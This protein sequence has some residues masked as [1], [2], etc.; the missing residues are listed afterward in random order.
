MNGLAKSIQN[1][2]TT[3]KLALAGVVIIII[4]FP[5]VLVSA[6][7]A[8]VGNGSKTSIEAKPTLP[9]FPEEISKAGELL[10]QYKSGFAPDENK[11]GES[12]ERLQKAFN[13]IG[14]IA[15]EKLYKN[16]N[17]EEL[18]NYYILKFNSK[19]TLQ[20]AAEKIYALPEIQDAKPN[21]Q[22]SFR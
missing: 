13:E 5:F 19:L 15:E 7:K 17:S 4:A 2:S 3:G 11:D 16:S 20:E 22:N 6:R 9:P 18:K 10:I 1:L 21:V 14:F 8:G 12:R